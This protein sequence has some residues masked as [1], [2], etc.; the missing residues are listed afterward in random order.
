VAVAGLLALCLCAGPS[1]TAAADSGQLGRWAWPLRPRPAVVAGFDPPAHDWLP[2]HRG[3][4]LAGKPGQPVHSAG[5]GVVTY[6]GR[7]AGIGVVVVRHGDLRTTYQPVRAAVRPGSV[8]S[9][10]E[11]I[12][13]LESAGSHCAPAVCLH[14]GLLRDHTY[15]DPLM[16]VGAG[17]P[18]LLPLAEPTS[19]LWTAAPRPPP[20]TARSG[21][22]DL[23]AAGPNGIV[24]LGGAGGLAGSALAG[25]R[26]LRRRRPA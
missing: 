22:A 6:A 3:V 16:L 14:W 9:A 10:G 12:G 20:A 13:R 15:L 21:E 11:V 5:A 2:G 4:D 23:P 19:A 24:L 18:R 25:G 26:Y 1:T 7:L 17:P 8:V